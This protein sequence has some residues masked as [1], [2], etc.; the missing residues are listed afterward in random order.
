MSLEDCPAVKQGNV[1][2]R[3]R[4]ERGE[5]CTIEVFSRFEDGELETLLLGAA[6]KICF[7]CEYMRQQL[8]DMKEVRREAI[9]KLLKDPE[10]PIGPASKI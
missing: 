9:E 3:C 5:P 10:N 6:I 2:C 7:N 8:E 4:Q 1:I